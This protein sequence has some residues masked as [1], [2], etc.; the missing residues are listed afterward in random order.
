[1]TN[2]NK[3][4]VPGVN[5][6]TQKGG[7]GGGNQYIQMP[8]IDVNMN[9]VPPRQGHTQQSNINYTPPGKSK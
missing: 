2:Q 1:M 4:N 8:K 6:T 3:P 7:F 9:I 5:K